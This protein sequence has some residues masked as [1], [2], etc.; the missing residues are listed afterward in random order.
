MP[1]VDTPP[2]TGAPVRNPAM[3][4]EE[5]RDVPESEPAMAR[6]RDRLLRA[7]ARHP[8]DCTP[9]WL[10]RQAGRYLPEYR[11][12]RARAGSFLALCS[13]PELACE[14]ALQ[15]LRRF[16]LDAAILFSDIL[17]IPHAM[18]LGLRFVEGE[19]PHFERPVRTPRDVEGLAPPDPEEELRYVTDTV[20]LLRAELEGRVPLIGFAGSPWTLATYMVEGGSSAHFARAKGLLYEQPRTAHRLLGVLSESVRACLQ[21]QAD[22]GAQVLMIFDTWGGVLPPDAFRTFS[23][24][25]LGRIV[26]ALKAETNTPIILFSKGSGQWLPDLAATGCDALGIDWTVDIGHARRQ[27]GDQVALQGNLDPSVLYTAPATIRAQTGRVLGAYGPGP[28]HVF[29]LGHGLRP[30]MD[31]DRIRTLVDAVHDQSRAFHA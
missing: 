14:V 6:R 27:V 8:V 11:K 25:Y 7:I 20:R 2:L 17:T 9:V 12:A 5:P 10:M 30:D 31:P 28:G 23:L 15:P 24:P 13:T 22:A 16:R 1:T 21:A 26:Q 29:N 19:G 18:G 3:P 4:R